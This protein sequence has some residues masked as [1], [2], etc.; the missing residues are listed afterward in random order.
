MCAE[1]LRM[2][3]TRPPPVYYMDDAPQAQG[4]PAR[5][6]LWRVLGWVSIA[7]SVVLV[8]ASLT[9]YGF[10]RRLDGQIDREHVDDKLGGNR[11]AKLNNSMN[12]LMMGSDS[13]AGENS[14]YGTEA[15]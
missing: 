12:I 11:P 1:M 2:Q 3:R 7:M 6:R 10:W 15:E 8:T 13:R 4:A 14:R 9:A 5:G